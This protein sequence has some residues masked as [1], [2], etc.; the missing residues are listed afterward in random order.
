MSPFLNRTTSATAPPANCS[1]LVPAIAASLGVR[2]SNERFFIRWGKKCK[3]KA[4]RLNGAAFT[5]NDG[6]EGQTMLLE[7][8]FHR[9]EEGFENLGRYLFKPDPHAQLR[10]EIAD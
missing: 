1:P 5:T 4:N 8:V 3:A 10:R 6:R 2:R 9:V 7:D